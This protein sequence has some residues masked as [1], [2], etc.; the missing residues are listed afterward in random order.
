[1]EKA[2]E[3]LV[4]QRK[5]EL[6]NRFKSKEQLLDFMI[7]RRKYFILKLLQHRLGFCHV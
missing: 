1:M 5:E 2:F 7:L 6:R 3:K 4:V